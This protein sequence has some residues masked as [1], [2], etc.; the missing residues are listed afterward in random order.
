MGSAHT[1]PTHHGADLWTLGQKL[2]LFERDVVWTSVS[3]LNNL[4][5]LIKAYS[6]KQFLSNLK[7][8]VMDEE[9]IV[10]CWAL[11]YLTNNFA[12]NV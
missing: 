3:F 12:L 8:F 11:C 9:F 4:T 10:C 7:T 5:L 6:G 1:F 2:T